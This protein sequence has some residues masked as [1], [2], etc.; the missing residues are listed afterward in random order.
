[1]TERRRFH[2]IEA[3]QGKPFHT[4]VY[5]RDPW[6]S[7]FPGMLR[8]ATDTWTLTPNG[9]GSSLAWLIRDGSTTAAAQIVLE[10]DDVARGAHVLRTRPLRQRDP[11]ARVRG[12]G[13]RFGAALREH[14]VLRGDRRDVHDARRVHRHLRSGVHDERSGGLSKTLAY[15]SHGNL[16]RTTALGPGNPTVTLTYDAL[17]NVTSVTEPEGARTENRIDPQDLLHPYEV[18]KDAAGIRLKTMTSTIL[19]TG[20]CSGAATR[21]EPSRRTN[22]TP[23]AGWRP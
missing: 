15:D 12:D 5:A 19:A 16:V 14:R 1:M 23:S 7:A 3:L 13:Q 4:A 9:S 21:T 22:S 6:T 10:P 11:R 17:G 20:A 2:Q 8:E 18:T